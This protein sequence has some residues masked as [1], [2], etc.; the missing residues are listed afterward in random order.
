MVGAQGRAGCSLV[1]V[2]GGGIQEA[3][4]QRDNSFWVVAPQT[5]LHTLGSIFWSFHQ[6][7]I[8]PLAGDKTIQTSA[9]G[10]HCKLNV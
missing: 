9:F 5:K 1:V 8:M 7:P 4:T 3:K 10:E 2:V 6:L